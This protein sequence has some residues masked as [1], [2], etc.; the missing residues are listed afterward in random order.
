[1]ASAIKGLLGVGNG[2]GHNG[3]GWQAFQVDQILKLT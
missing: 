2:A 3:C 1:M